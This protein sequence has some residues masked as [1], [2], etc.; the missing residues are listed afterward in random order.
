[1]T[2]NETKQWFNNY[3]QDISEE[4]F[5]EIIEEEPQNEEE[6]EEKLDVVKHRT[7]DEEVCVKTNKEEIEELVYVYGINKAIA[8]YINEWGPLENI[9]QNSVGGR[10]YSMSLLYNIVNNEINVSYEAYL[11]YYKD[12]HDATSD[13]GFSARLAYYKDNHD[14]S[15]S[16]SDSESESGFNFE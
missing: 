8:S 6:Y 4:I 1:M 16:E 14:K 15:D 11:A 10:E 5:N 13:V 3:I 12:N 9:P 2:S 7:I